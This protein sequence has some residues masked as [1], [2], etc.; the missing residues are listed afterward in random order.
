M[1]EDLLPIL[2]I[3][4]NTLLI[5]A[6]IPQIVKMLRTKK[7]GDV[8]LT[9]WV[10]WFLGDGCFLAYSLIEADLYSSILFGFFGLGNIT[11]LALIILYGKVPRGD[12]ASKKS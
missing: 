1:K 4:G 6:Y 9:M 7:V 5:A 2:G 11:I 8:S 12:K 3:V 10:L